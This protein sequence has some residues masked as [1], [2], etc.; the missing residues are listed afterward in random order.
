MK[1]SGEALLSSFVL[2]IAESDKVDFSDEEAA[3]H[4]TFLGTCHLESEETYSKSSKPL[5]YGRK[6]SVNLDLLYR[7]QI[8]SNLASATEFDRKC[9]RIRCLLKKLN[10]KVKDNG[11]RNNSVIAERKTISKRFLAPLKHLSFMSI[12]RSSK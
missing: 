2:E 1:K 9:E 7:A 8:N 4:I 12:F 11:I 6:P 10:I 5:T 3:E